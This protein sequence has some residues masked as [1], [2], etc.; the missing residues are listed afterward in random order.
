MI[1]VGKNIR[2]W[3]E[4][5]G[6]TQDALAEK[7]HVTRQAVSN[8]ETEKNQ[9]DLEMLEAAARALDVELEDLLREQ[10]GGYPQF[11]KKAVVWVIAL[12]AVTLLLLAD[13]VFIVPRL[14]ELKE[15]YYNGWWYWLNGFAVLPLLRI[16]PGMLAPAVISLWRDVQPEG[17][18]KT[19]LRVL[20]FLLLIPAVL[21]MLWL[22]SV[23]LPFSSRFA[24]A[25]LADRSGI[26]QALVWRVLPF[27]AGIC[28]FLGYVRLKTSE[29]RTV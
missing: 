21:A 7:L 20:P 16:A 11:Q 17:W 15:K 18:L 6:L 4:Q 19:A 9:P 23:G 22:F 14:V 8:W 3:R 13:R 29:D 28:M 26:W 2:K 12:C 25:L 1:D 24:A 27:L 5:R 10:R